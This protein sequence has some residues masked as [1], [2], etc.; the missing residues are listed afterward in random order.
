MNRRGFLRGLLGVAAAPVVA[1]V[2][3]AE[4]E[5]IPGV[6]EAAELPCEVIDAGAVLPEYVVEINA[7]LDAFEISTWQDIELPRT[8][9]SLSPF[10]RRRPAP[11][12]AE[13]SCAYGALPPS[14][15]EAVRGAIGAIVRLTIRHSEG[16]I[17]LVG[18]LHGVTLGS[19][20]TC[21]IT[22]VRD[23]T[24]VGSAA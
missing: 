5:W 18:L 15:Y 22:D 19:R 13:I 11:L 12:N 14:V 7:E 8:F 16:T 9:G 20:I 1:K 21:S 23:V 4:G 24:V 6:V 3:A 17:A 10:V 2:A